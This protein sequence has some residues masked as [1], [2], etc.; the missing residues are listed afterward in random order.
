[1]FHWEFFIWRY[2]FHNCC[3]G[4]WPSNPP[5]R[6]KHFRL[7]FTEASYDESRYARIAARA[8][9]T[10]HHERILSAEECADELPGIVSRMDQPMADASCAPTWLLS[11]DLP[12]KMLQLRLVG[13]GRM[14]YGLVMSIIL[15][16]R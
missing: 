10:I 9:G 2:R 14:S 11:A 16:S 3:R 1:M 6:L 12:V 5:D 8:Y 7:V 13:T 4:L 15:A